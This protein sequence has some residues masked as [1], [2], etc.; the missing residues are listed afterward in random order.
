MK[1]SSDLPLFLRE[2]LSFQ[3][4]FLHR[5]FTTTWRSPFNE[6]KPEITPSHLLSS[7]VR[8][9]AFSSESSEPAHLMEYFVCELL[10][11]SFVC[12]LE[13]EFH[14]WIFH[15]HHSVTWGWPENDCCFQNCAEFDLVELSFSERWYGTDVKTLLYSTLVAP[16]HGEF[17]QFFA[18]K[19]SRRIAPNSTT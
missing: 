9:G 5:L 16:R 2:K 14:S 11:K 10:C 6:E 1:I 19:N 13:N 15:D 3:A 7:L 4:T 12:F 8:K 18:A 17:H